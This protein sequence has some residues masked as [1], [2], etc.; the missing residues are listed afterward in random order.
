MG[1]IDITGFSSSSFRLCL[2]EIINSGQFEYLT[3]SDE[4]D[5]YSV[6]SRRKT[7]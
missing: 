2:L 5:G 4:F 7:D 1:L 3:N 6:A